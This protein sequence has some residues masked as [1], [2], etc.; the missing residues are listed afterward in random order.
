MNF[1]LHRFLSVSLLGL[2]CTALA[3]G[4]GKS[5]TPPETKA[6]VSA[7]FAPPVI[8]ELFV[9]A[10]KA[11]VP[12]P[13]GVDAAAKRAVERAFKDPTRFGQGT[14][15]QANTCVANVGLGYILLKNGMPVADADAGQARVVV[16]AELACPHVANG[17]KDAPRKDVFRV[18][19]VDDAPFNANS[20]PDGAAILVMLLTEQTKRA[21]MA[22]R[23]QAEMRGASDTAVITA[24]K[25]STRPGVLAEAA[26][27][28]GERKLN[29]AFA[30]LIA[31]T[32]HAEGLVAVRAAAALGLLG[33]PD[34]DAIR[35]LVAMTKGPSLER[36][37]V[38]VN[39]LADIGG[40][41]AA[42]YLDAIAQS[43]PEAGLRELAR[44]AALRASPGKDA[45]RQD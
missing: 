6:P 25:T 27:E 23:G 2:G 44:D 15:D 7:P 38:A 8:G 43:H 32:K 26:S 22:L 4:C 3:A 5:D 35:A 1:G 18:T 13:D 37:V 12:V 17:D 28:A 33:R 39:A 29:D 10:M 41:D 30:A 24:L 31:Q 40:K 16:E 19:T 14:K 20:G 11:D 36:H 45:G 21:A 9:G 34:V 42:R